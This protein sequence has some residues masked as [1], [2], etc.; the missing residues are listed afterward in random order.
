MF[1]FRPVIQKLHQLIAPLPGLG[2]YKVGYLFD[3]LV[4]RPRMSQN[5]STATSFNTY[6]QMTRSG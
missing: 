5:L 4:L 6:E 2:L 3:Q 1:S